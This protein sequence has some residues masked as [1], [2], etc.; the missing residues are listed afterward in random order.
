MCRFARNVFV[1]T[2]LE[3]FL[4]TPIRTVADVVAENCN[5][6]RGSGLPLGRLILA[7][8]SVKPGD[9]VQS[10]A[11]GP[12]MVVSEVL[13][14]IKIRCVWRV[15]GK[16]LADTFHPKTLVRVERD[17]GDVLGLSGETDS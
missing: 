5:I 2:R 16:Y 13:S 1:S 12:T 11:G 14:S 8:N 3:V 15:D 7:D 9:V 4:L 17:L 10:S 6:R